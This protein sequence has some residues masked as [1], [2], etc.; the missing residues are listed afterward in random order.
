MATVQ[1]N[2]RLTTQSPNGYF[3]YLG[4]L[5]WVTASSTTHPNHP[6]QRN[7]LPNGNS[8]N[9]FGLWNPNNPTSS[10]IGTIGNA[11]STPTIYE[12]IGSATQNPYGLDSNTV[13]IGA[14]GTKF[15]YSTTVNFDNK[16][17][18]YYGFMYVVGDNN[19][20]GVLVDECGDVECFE[21]EV[22][23]GFPDFNNGNLS[24]CEGTIPST[25]DLLTTLTNANTSP[26]LTLGGT[27]SSTNQIPGTTLNATSGVI[28]N[29]IQPETP[30]TYIYKYTLNS[31]QQGAYHTISL[32]TCAVEEVLITITIT[33]TVE[34]GLGQSVAVCN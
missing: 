2:T 6:S 18:G 20:D 22:L 33:D 29:I 7:I 14:K 32:G 17:P 11:D 25:V 23:E 27:F 24:Y 3:V 21:I 5:S 9:C 16:L 15:S 13:P 28:S 26:A 1:L 30:G 34:A 19:N 8:T 12:Y 31:A 10:P 4:Y